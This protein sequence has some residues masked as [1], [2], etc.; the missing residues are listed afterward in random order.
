MFNVDAII[1]LFNLVLK[2]AFFGGFFLL[3]SNLIQFRKATSIK[4]E[5][6]NLQ[7]R[8]S[9]LRLSLKS[10]IKKKSYVLRA[11]FNKGAITEGN[12]ID[13]TIKELTENPFETSQDFQNY[14]ELSRKIVNFIHVEN[15]TEPDQALTIENNFMCS[16][17]K[18]EMDIVRIIKEMSKISARINSRVLENNASNP[19]QPIKKSDSFVFEALSDINR[20][21]KD[22][23]PAE[24][25][26]D[27][28][29]DKKAS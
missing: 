19:R 15:K 13:N 12:M 28:D 3:V 22:Q 2:I 5:I 29:S 8:L 7:A 18:T 20:I 23:D 25:V 1:D 27:E 9:K 16:D 21:F 17:F 6:Q 11:S 10:K 4:A 24:I 14:F 26:D